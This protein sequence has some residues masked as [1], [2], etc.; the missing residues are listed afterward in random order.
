MVT[1]KIAF[2]PPVVLAAWFAFVAGIVY[3]ALARPDL[4]RP[5]LFAHGAV[6]PEHLPELGADQIVLPT[7]ELTPSQVVETQLAGLADPKADG[8]GILQCY[9]MASPGNRNVTGPLD[10]FGAM[11]RHEPFACLAKPQATLVGQPEV[12][13]VIAKLL[14]TVIDE[15]Q[16]MHAFTFLLAKQTAGPYKDCWMTEAVFPAGKLAPPGTDDAAKAHSDSA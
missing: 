7:P 4:R 13:G 15:R 6:E 11:V 2:L 12:E 9:V 10:R 8:I 14:V 3:T 1:R 5:A 16:H